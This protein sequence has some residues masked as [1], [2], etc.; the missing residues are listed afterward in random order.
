MFVCFERLSYFHE[1]PSFDKCR[2]VSHYLPCNNLTQNLRKVGNLVESVFSGLN[3]SG[4]T[5]VNSPSQKWP[6]SGYY[7]TIF[8]L[9]GKVAQAAA[10]FNSIRF[11]S[12]E[13]LTVCFMVDVPGASGH[14]CE[15]DQDDST[16]CD[17]SRPERPRNYCSVD[18]MIK[19][20]SHTPTA[21]VLTVSPPYPRLCDET[22]K[23]KRTVRPAKTERV[24]KCNFYFALSSGLRN[25]IEIA[26][27]IRMVQV[28]RRGNDLTAD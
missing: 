22:A 3:F 26:L 20:I 17:H 27:R 10:F 28:N 8:E 13:Y 1:C 4:L 24:G 14:R 18:Q 25:V 19:K 5:L 6:V 23:H 16:D 7:V 12:G 2:R 21:C 15:R 11:A 9:F